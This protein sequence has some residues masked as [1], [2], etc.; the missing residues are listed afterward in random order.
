MH[1]FGVSEKYVYTSAIVAHPWYYREEIAYH[2]N[3]RLIK[4]LVDMDL[5]SVQHLVLSLVE[6]DGLNVANI[7]L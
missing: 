2:G 3:T 7:L 1:E 5:L 4:D 6:R